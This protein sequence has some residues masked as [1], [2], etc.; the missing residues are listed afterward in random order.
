MFDIYPNG[1]LIKSENGNLDSEKQDFYNLTV[2]A[3]IRN[4]VL[5]STQNFGCVTKVPYVRI[6]R[7]KRSKVFSYC[8]L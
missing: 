2:E 5:V 8:N 3:R 7:F 4:S 6:R 1:S